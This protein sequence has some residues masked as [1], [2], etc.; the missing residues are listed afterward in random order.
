M[1][2]LASSA[3]SGGCRIAGLQF[4]LGESY[5]PPMR[6]RAGPIGESSDL[7]RMIAGK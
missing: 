5:N 2:W 1:R 7:C 3:A 4:L 6:M